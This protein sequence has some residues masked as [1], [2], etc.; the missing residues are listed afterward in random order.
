MK[1]FLDTANLE[2]IKK[3]AQTGL[4][5]GVTTNPTHLS[6]ES[7]LPAEIVKQICTLL[8]DGEIS[9]EITEKAPSAVYEQAKKIAALHENI[10]VKIPCCAAYIPVINKLVAEDVALNITLVFSAL[11]ALMMA[12]LGVLYVSPFVG[13]LDDIDADGMQL[14]GDIREMLETYDYETEILVASVRSVRQVHQAAMLGAHVATIK[15]EI[16]DL[17]LQHP[18]TDAGMQI[19]DTDWQKLGVKH[20]P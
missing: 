3:G 6:K 4:I 11:Q 10:I 7:G 9:V 8:P 2:S 19:F 20:F 16:F 5:D 15:S 12:K 13:R 17:M 1:I 18:L 14:V